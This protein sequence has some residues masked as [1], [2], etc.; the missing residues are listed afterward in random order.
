MEPQTDLT[1]NIPEPTKFCLVTLTTFNRGLNDKH[2]DDLSALCNCEAYDLGR[3]IEALRGIH[4]ARCGNLVVDHRFIVDYQWYYIPR[5][6]YS[7][8]M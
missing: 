6:L 3:A 8:D 5:T 2:Y 7:Q 4:N 1:T